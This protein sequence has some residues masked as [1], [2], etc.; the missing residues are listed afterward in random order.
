MLALVAI[1]MIVPCTYPVTAATTYYPELKLKDKGRTWYFNTYYPD[2]ADPTI[3]IGFDPGQI[4]WDYVV[5]YYIRHGRTYYVTPSGH[6]IDYDLNLVEIY[7]DSKEIPGGSGVT[8]TTVIGLLL[9]GDSFVATGP[10]WMWRK[11]GG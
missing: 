7:F 3:T 9:D 8:Q 5:C 1:N 11:A 10:G 4:D 2:P 6:S